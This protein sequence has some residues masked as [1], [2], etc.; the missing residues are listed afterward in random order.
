MPKAKNSKPVTPSRRQVATSLSDADMTTSRVD[1]R[2]FLSR[3]VLAGS[4]AVGA[5]AAAAC[6]SGGTEGTDSDSE[7]H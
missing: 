3:A 2:S 5:A 6:P 7:N 1:R 4:I